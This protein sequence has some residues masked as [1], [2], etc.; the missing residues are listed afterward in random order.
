[1]Q[2]VTSQMPGNQPSSP[3]FPSSLPFLF[4]FLSLRHG[5]TYWY[6]GK[7]REGHLRYPFP[8]ARVT[9]REPSGGGKGIR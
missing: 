5:N 3:L 2:V 8:K 6:G 4:S 7:E 1:M 9:A